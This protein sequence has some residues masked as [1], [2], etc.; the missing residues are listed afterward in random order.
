[1][2]ALSSYEDKEKVFKQEVFILISKKTSLFK[3]QSKLKADSFDSC[4]LLN[5]LL[6]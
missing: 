2:V 5:R 6:S 1:M 3:H 4:K